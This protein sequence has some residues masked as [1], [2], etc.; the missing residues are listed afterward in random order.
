VPHPAYAGR[1]GRIRTSPSLAAAARAREL[2]ASGRDVLD[3]TLG[4]MSE[5]SIFVASH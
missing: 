1:V 4:E 3:L 2:S 5:V